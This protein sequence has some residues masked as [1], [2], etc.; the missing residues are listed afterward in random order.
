M[1]QII[2]KSFIAIALISALT[3]PVLVHAASCGGAKTEFVSCGDGAGLG[4]IASMIKM[5]IYALTALIGIVAVG[6][7]AYAAILYASARD[8]K[9]QVE[10]AIT[11]IRNIVIGLVMYGFIVAIIN[12]LVPGGVIG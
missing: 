2:I 6:G 8:N 1:K 12:W 3:A 4:A 5:G 11:I 9:S 10:Q 7:L